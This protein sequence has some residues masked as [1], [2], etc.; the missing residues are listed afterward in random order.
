MVYSDIA[1]KTL[2]LKEKIN[3]SLASFWKDYSSEKQLCDAIPDDITVLEQFYHELLDR[4][5]NEYVDGF[6]CVF[7]DAFPVIKQ[8]DKISYH[9][10]DQHRDQYPDYFLVEGSVAYKLLQHNEKIL[11]H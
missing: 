9:V 10:L 6:I 8:V 11:S 1:L 7:D 5:E 3:P 2:A 4:L